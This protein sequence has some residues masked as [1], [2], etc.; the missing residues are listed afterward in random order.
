MNGDDARRVEAELLDVLQQVE[1][2]RAR[3]HRH[4]C[5]RVGGRIVG[6]GLDQNPLLREVRDDD[7]LVVPAAAQ[8]VQLESLVASVRTFRSVMAVKVVRGDFASR[9]GLRCAAL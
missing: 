1:R 6:I 3:R 2:V 8:V 7:A 9:S 5:G 4:R